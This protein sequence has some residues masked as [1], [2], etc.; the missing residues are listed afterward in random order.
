MSQSVFEEK[1]ML[2]DV[3]SAQKAITGEYN[4]FT[5]ECSTPGVRD[6]FLS[7]LD[8]EHLIQ[9]DVFDEMHKRGW[10]PPQNSRRS[11]RQGRNSKTPSRNKN[12]PRERAAGQPAHNFPRGL[13]LTE[14]ARFPA[15]NREYG[16]GCRVRR[17]FT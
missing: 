16:R 4:T 13:F 6:S 12:P 2:E 10:Y 11:S 5:N 15:Y 7:L 1:E 9:A 8:E 14:T 3:L 17:P